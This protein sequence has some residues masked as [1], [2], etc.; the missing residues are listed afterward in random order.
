MTDLDHRAS[1]KAKA[2]AAEEPNP[3]EVMHVTEGCSKVRSS[4]R[5]AVFRPQ[6]SAKA[7]LDGVAANQPG[8]KILKLKGVVTEDSE[9]S[10]DA[11]I[12]ALGQNTTIQVVYFQGFGRGMLDPQLRR[13]LQVLQRPECAVWAMNIGESPRLS[14][15]A[16]WAFAEGMKTTK[17]G[18]LFAEPNHLPFGVKPSM[19]DTLRENRKLHRW[20][21]LQTH[22]ENV[23]VVAK[24]DK[25]W[26]HPAC[27]TRNQEFLAR[28]QDE[29]RVSQGLAPK[30]REPQQPKKGRKRGGPTTARK[31]VRGGGGSNSEA[32]REL[33]DEVW[34]TGWR[35]EKQK[36]ARRKIKFL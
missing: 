4:N 20:H 36:Q 1:K 30:E 19:I 25:M 17:L 21:D 24:C 28:Q 2:S 18:A 22:P 7:L 23:E 32:T 31:Q 16:W 6:A 5:Q 29:R 14:D 8:L 34:A 27:S 13:L 10:V 26:W 12:E 33:Q 11:I 9:Q 35:G 15:D 3:R